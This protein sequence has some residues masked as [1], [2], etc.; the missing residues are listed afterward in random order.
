MSGS[1][2]KAWSFQST[3]KADFGPIFGHGTTA[4]EKGKLFTEHLRFG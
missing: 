4:E 3:V 2:F 1:V